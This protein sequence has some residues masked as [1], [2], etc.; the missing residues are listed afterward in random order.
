MHRRILSLLLAAG[1]ALWAGTPLAASAA[2]QAA[3]TVT[4]L[5]RSRQRHGDQVRVRDRQAGPDPHRNEARRATWSGASR[6]KLHLKVGSARPVATRSWTARAT[7]HPDRGLS[8]GVHVEKPTG[9][10][11]RWVTCTPWQ[12]APWLDLKRAI[13]AGTIADAS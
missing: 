4:D 7:E 8:L 11:P 10:G 1:P 2:S 13:V 3:P 9:G 6:A 12:P 5:A